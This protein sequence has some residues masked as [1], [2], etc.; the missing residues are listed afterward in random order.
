MATNHYT[1]L[2][3]RAGQKLPPGHRVFRN[4]L[5]EG[6]QHVDDVGKIASDQYL[7]AAGKA[8]K[9]REQLSTKAIP[10]LQ[11]AQRQLQHLEKQHALGA[12]NQ[13][14]RVLG[15]GDA[16]DAERRMVLRAATPA[17]RL[18][19]IK[20]DSKMNVAAQLGGSSLTGI[21]DDDLALAFEP[22][23]EKFDPAGSAMQKDVADSIGLINV[24]LE[25]FQ[26]DLRASHGA[27]DGTA[28][29][30]P[31]RDDEYYALVRSVEAPA[32]SDFERAEAEVSE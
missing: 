23:A 29:T 24:A 4:I 28:K 10:A 14:N 31:L 1:Q 11:K 30:R 13:R 18:R 5:A 2:L 3:I 7:N 8:A 15:K 6:V 20:S 19:L 17:D 25:A 21:S 22:L 16:L 27:T 32:I 9:V 12:Q 26:N